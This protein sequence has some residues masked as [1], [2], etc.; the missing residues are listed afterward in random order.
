MTMLTHRPGVHPRD[1]NIGTKN[2]TVE[3]TDTISILVHAAAGPPEGKVGAR[4]GSPHPK[5][6]LSTPLP[7]SPAPGR[8][9]GRCGRAAAGAALGCWQPPRCPVAHLPCRGCR[10]HPRF[11]A[12]GGCHHPPEQPW[13]PPTPGSAHPHLPAGPRA[14]GGRHGR[15]PQPLPGP[16][17]AEAAARGVRG[18]RLDPPAVRGGRGAGPRRG[19]PPGK[20]LYLGCSCAKAP[21]GN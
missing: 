11:L 15:A 14:G 3:P 8:R 17:A 4:W 16:L 12:E 5:P 6:P 19:S 13:S 7:P 21:W 1:R 20:Q 18:E 10:P 2:L 9:C